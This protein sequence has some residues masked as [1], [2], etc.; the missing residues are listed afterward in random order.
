MEIL[1]NIVSTINGV[2][3]G[4]Y[5]LALLLG[6]GIFLTVG[7]NVMPIRK[8]PTG[9]RLLWGGRRSDRSDAGELSPF[10]ALMTSLSATVGTGNIAGVATAVVLG[11]PGALFWMWIT[12]LVGM[13][14][15]YSEAVL[16]VKYREVDEE[17]NHS[18]GP[19]YYIRN[20]LGEK[21]TWLAGAFAFFGAFAA[22][23]I[24]NTVQSN[25]VADGLN[26]AFGIP[27]WIS[28]LVLFVLV[29]AVVLGGVKRVGE[30]AGKLVP[31]MGIGYFLCG[32]IVLFVN[33]AEIPA[34]F[35]LIVDSAFNGHAATGGFAGA[36]MV[37]A[38][39][40][41]VARGVFSNE[42]GLGS[43]AIAH[44][45]AKTKDPVKQGMVAM[46]GTFIDTIIVC[47]VTGLAIVSTGV[48]QTGVKGAPL[49]AA[50]FEASLPGVG[51]YMVAISLAIFAFTTILGWSVYGERC[52]EFLFGKGAIKPFRF[53]WVL[54]VPVGT[55]VGLD[56]VWLLADTFNA[57]MALPNL[58]ALLLLSPVVFKLTREYFNKKEN[59]SSAA[60]EA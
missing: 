28:G 38:I 30:V 60:N 55:V 14:T 24:G 50:A 29:G 19:M 27:N 25:S 16:A 9:F 23:G 35:A 52:V 20:G 11:G 46:L 4:P 15:K 42:A 12:A 45:H 10:N 6:T 32:L 36:A 51:E 54:V 53:V 56:F 21:W 3:W 5:M 59:N 17:G 34:A 1:N 37:A 57:L 26:S 44:A 13:A 22:F 18:G 43:A 2:V 58:I 39:R 40:F 33:A 31:L 47:T 49:T 7:L 48:W 8:I 41:G